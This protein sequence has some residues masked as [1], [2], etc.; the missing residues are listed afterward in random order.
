MF[1]LGT[2]GAICQPCRI[3]FTRL[4]GERSSNEGAQNSKRPTPAPAPARARVS[5]VSYQTL[6][7]SNRLWTCT[8][9][10]RGLK[11]T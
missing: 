3:D 4:Q 7:D 10:P 9:R 8:L 6:T 11:E 5:E 1:R 2:T